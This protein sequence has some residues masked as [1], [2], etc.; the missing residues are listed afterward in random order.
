MKSVGK[1]DPATLDKLYRG[2]EIEPF[3]MVIPLT[4]HA[5]DRGSLF[6]VLH[7]HELPGLI[8]KRFGQVYTVKSPVRGTIRG[9]HRHQ[10]L[11]DYF[12][13]VHGRAK[14]VMVRPK[15][16]EP[17]VAD[18]IW[19]CTLAEE[20]PSVVVIPPLLFHGWVALTDET[21]LLSIGSEVYDA[22]Q[23]DEE[24]IPFDTFGDVWGIRPK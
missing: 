20:V 8:E 9:F 15:E 22:Q 12:C 16:H 1:F 11:W 7:E 21:I 5:D 2:D 14:V 13:V 10:V 18:E 6:E 3:P 19:S 24:R 4:V 23:P 17:K